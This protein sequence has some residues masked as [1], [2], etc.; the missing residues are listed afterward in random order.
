VQ[1]AAGFLAE[2]D[3]VPDLRAAPFHFSSRYR[4]SLRLAEKRFRNFATTSMG[5][6]FDTAAALVGF[7]RPITFEGQ[8]TMWLEQ[9]ARRAPESEPYPFSVKD[10]ELDFRPLLEAVIRDRVRGREPA[11]IARAFH[12][13]ITSGISDAIVRLCEAHRID[14]VVLSGGVFQNELLLAGLKSQCT[15]QG[16]TIWTNSTVP[17]NDGGISLGQ[18]AMAAMNPE[19]LRA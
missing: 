19:A 11:D 9:L 2:I 17:P 14:T 15:L 4:A 13:G 6:L 18:A 1:C 16:S 10:G 7:T 12:M 5:R 8:A 3:E